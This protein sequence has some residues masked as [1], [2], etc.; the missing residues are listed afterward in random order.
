MESRKERTFAWRV[1]QDWIVEAWDLEVRREGDVIPIVIVRFGEAVD[2]SRSMAVA[3]RRSLWPRCRWSKVPPT[4][5]EVCGL[6]DDDDDDD[7][8]E[9]DT[10]T[11]IDGGMGRVDPAASLC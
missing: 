3:V 4:A 5:I 8:G 11:G 9:V 2:G 10:G 1:D 6:C 7:D